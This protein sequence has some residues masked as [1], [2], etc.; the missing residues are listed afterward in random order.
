MEFGL[1][2]CMAGATSTK[3][4]QAFGALLEAARYADETRCDPWE[5][6]VEI[7][8]LRELGLLEND[9]RYLVRL[10]YVN[11]AG[12]VTAAGSIRRRFRPAGE[13]RFTKRTCFVITPVGIAAAAERWNAAA[14]LQ[15]IPD[16]TV[17][18]PNHYP[19]MLACRVPNWDGERRT[20][21][22]EGRLVKRFRW[23]AANQQGILF[24]FHEEGWPVRI[25]D[26]LPP[27]ASIVAKQRLSDTIKCLN[28]KQ[29]NPLIRFRGDGT[30]QG[31]VWESLPQQE[32]MSAAG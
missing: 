15:P 7:Q 27:S 11:H 31:V 13:P 14:D 5:F 3:L 8:L 29:A 17:R 25:D 12:E 20:L 19:P 4:Q 18:H 9:L 16:A 21:S 2:C 26:P 10:R 30:G 23:Q 22:F 1:Q 32:I 28:R 6:A 24:A